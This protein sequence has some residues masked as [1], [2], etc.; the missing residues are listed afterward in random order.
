MRWLGVGLEDAQRCGAMP[1]E[2][3]QAQKLDRPVLGPRKRLE[4]IP[5]EAWRTGQR[6]IHLTGGAHPTHS[7]HSVG[8]VFFCSV[9]GCYGSQKLFALS[10]P[11]ERAATPSRRYLLKK[12]QAGC[13]PRTGQYLGEVVRAD[14][15]KAMP[16]TATR[17]RSHSA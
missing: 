2:L 14:R 16:L 1:T 10:N 7:L 4:V 12:M 17:R 5:D 3:T 8:E 15:T 6:Q 9:C 13:H 11:C